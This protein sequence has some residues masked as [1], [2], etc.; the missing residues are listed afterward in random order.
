M[1]IERPR[2]DHAQAR[3]TPLETSFFNHSSRTARADGLDSRF[4]AAQY[5]D[6]AHSS[7]AQIG[8]TRTARDGY[9]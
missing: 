5:V 6:G 2:T 4:F 3:A 9:Q 1:C 8:S 7:T